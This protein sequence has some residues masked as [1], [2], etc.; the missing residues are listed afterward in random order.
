MKLLMENLLALQNLE[1]G[2]VRTADVGQRI[3][4]LRSKIPTQI[5]RHY[6]RLMARGKKG[7]AIVRNRVCSECHISVPIG[8]LGSLIFG[9]DIQL[10]D[11]CDRYLYLPEEEP[12]CPGITSKNKPQKHKKK[13]AINA[14]P[15]A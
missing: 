4:E 1:M 8:T 6:G 11:S 13:A 9:S 12:V 10:C 5:L 2:S 14:A 7:V 15:C 3:A